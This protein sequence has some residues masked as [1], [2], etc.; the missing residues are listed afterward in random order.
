MTV[1]ACVHACMFL[2]E[3][4][5]ASACLHVFLFLMFCLSFVFLFPSWIQS[6]AL[7]D[8]VSDKLFSFLDTLSDQKCMESL[9]Q[10]TNP[11]LRWMYSTILTQTARNLHADAV[12][13]AGSSLKL[14]IS[15]VVL[16][17][18]DSATMKCLPTLLVAH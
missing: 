11:K 7:S 17:D 14:R 9:Y 12:H 13:S 10:A 18:N 6:G 8:T 1:N 5:R 4:A 16:D 15:N 2:F 3:C